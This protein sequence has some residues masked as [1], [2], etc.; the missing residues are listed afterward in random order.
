MITMERSLPVNPPGTHSP[1]TRAEVWKG[2]TLKADN[3]LPFVPQMTYCKVVERE[4]EDRFVRE[5]DFR[6]D[7]MRERVTLE[8]EKT[9][10]FERLAGP[11]LGTIRNYIDENEKGELSLRFVFALEILGM[12]AGSAEEKEYAADMEKAYL[13][14]VDATLGAIRRLHDETSAPEWLRSYYDDVDNRRMDAFLAHHAPDAKIF[15]GNNPPAVGIEAIRGAIGGLW[16]AI[17]GLKHRIINVWGD[18]SRLVLE[19]ATTYSRKDGKD[20]TVPCVSILERNASGKITE[21]RVH[22]DMAPVFA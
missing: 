10:T 9:V 17:D 8:P 18:D 6:G 12:A 1:V 3:A 5:I 15:Y 2:L 19:A 20:V 14:A 16:Q 11:V 22:I 4:T 7:R 13:G 21:L